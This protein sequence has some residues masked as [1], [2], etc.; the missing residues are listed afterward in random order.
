MRTIS[1]ETTLPRKPTSPT[2]IKFISKYPGFAL[3]FRRKDSLTLSPHPS[4]TFHHRVAHLAARHLLRTLGP[5]VAGAQALCDHLLHRALDAVGGGQ[6]GEGVAVHHRHREDGRQ[7]VRQ[8]PAGDV[9][10]RTEDR[11]VHALVVLVQGSRR[12][13]ADRAGQHRRGIR[14]DVAEDVAGDEGVE[15]FGRA[16]QL[17][18]RVVDVHVGELDLGESFATSIMTSFHSSEHS[19]TLAFSTEHS[20]LPRFIAMPKATCATRRTSDSEYSIVLKPTRSPFRTSIPRGWPKYTSPV[21][22]RTIMISSPDTTS[23]LSDDAP[24]SSGYS[25]AGR[26]LANRLS[27]LRMRN[28]PRSGRSGR[29]SVSYCGPPPAPSSTASASRASLSVASGSGSPEA[30]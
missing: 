2:F 21:S 3:G 6:V 17:F 14:Q 25:S 19:S 24:A 22:S 13:H 8:V 29:S 26:R 18:R 15:L 5:D 16:D 27:S 12:Q 20:F 7:R 28:R 9:G 10:G 30:S 4:Q 23:G 11:L 1:T